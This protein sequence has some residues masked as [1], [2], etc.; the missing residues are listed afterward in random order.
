MAHTGIAYLIAG[1][2]TTGIWCPACALPS[3]ISCEYQLLDED[4]FH[5]GDGPARICT[6]CHES[7]PVPGAN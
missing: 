5:P 3:G 1:K 7:I 2:M 6:E 4:G